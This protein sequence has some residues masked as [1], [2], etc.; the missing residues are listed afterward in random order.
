MQKGQSYIEVLVAMAV[1]GLVSAAAFLLFFGG[2]SISIDSVNAQIANDYATEGSEAVRSIRDRSWAELS[3]GS[4]GVVLMN[5]QWYFASST[6][7]TKSIFTRT[8][9]ISTID[10]NTKKASTTVVWQ[11]DPVRSQKT[12]L[13]E[14]LTSW[15]IFQ[16][17]G[18]DTGGSGIVGDWQHPVTLGSI[19]LG[20]GNAATDLDTKNKYV[21][22]SASASSV[23]KPDFF[24]INATNGQS[25]SIVSS[26]D[27]GSKGLN[28]VDVAGSYAY[29][30]NQDVNAQLKVISVGD[31]NNPTVA[32]SFK[33]PNVSG[34][35]AIGNAIFYYANKIYIATQQAT[36]PEFH[37]LDVS[38]PQNPSELGSYE[39]GANV[40]DIFIVGTTAY[41]ATSDDSKELIVLD[42]SNPANI[43]QLGSY[44]AVG[45]DDG[46]GVYVV[47]NLAYLGRAG[48]TSDFLVLDITNPASIKTLG[49]ANLGN[50][51]VNAITVRDSLA[52]LG[53]SDSNREFQVWNIASSTNPT[54]WSS[55]NFPQVASGIDFE[56][57]LVYVAV[58]SNDALRIITSQ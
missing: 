38:N 52:F 26:L 58:R 47:G 18:G 48:G 45:A 22:I 55:F 10:S 50:V 33:L 17:T 40:N 32:A 27:V 29:T 37:V 39:V 49:T 7:D 9:Y 41:L 11:T 2:R 31:I 28:A 56:N 23:S 43:T 57:N 42:V 19:D 8:V 5:G 54:L 53:T 4:H 1:F 24:I 44:D 14:L 21:Y 13:V 15:S 34:S 20:P 12:E 30:A 36:G 46:Q 3:D 35:G 16:N 6:S 25:P 51:S